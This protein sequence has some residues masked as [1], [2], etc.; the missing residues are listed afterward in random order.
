MKIRMLLIVTLCVLFALPL[1]AQNL[2]IGGDMESEDGW[3]ITNYK[4]DLTDQPL[5]EFGSTVDSITGVP[6]TGG[7]LRVTMEDGTNG[8]QLL[9]FQ[10][11]ECTA[12]LEY[13]ASALIKVL[14]YGSPE[15]SLGQWFQFYV[16]TEEPLFYPD[17]TEYN[18]G[19]AKMFNMS[20]WSGDLNEVWED[21]DGYW[22]DVMQDSEIE[23]S[24]TWV[25]PGT[26]GETVQVTVGMKFGSSANAEAYYDLIVDEVMFYGPEGTAVKSNSD[27]A[28][29]ESFVLNQNYPN[30]FNPTTNISFSLPET[31]NTTLKVYNAIGAEVAT[32]VNGQMQAGV[33]H[34]SF[35]A[36]D[37]PSGIYYYSLQQN[38]FTAT[39]KCVV[40]K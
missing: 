35:E 30:P 1:L 14:D 20:S 2:I 33:H 37:L 25:C 8:A 40:L 3:E 31:A 18:P 7:K 38:N 22:E 12:G 39:K 10:L 6:N 29:P 15:G 34:V 28:T 4:E 32:L 17:A 24:P 27:P 16:S 36:T 11:V 19:G 23:T 13:T 26:E 21:F 5:F 9:F